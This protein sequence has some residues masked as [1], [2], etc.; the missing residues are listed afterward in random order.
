MLFIKGEDGKDGESG[1]KGQKGEPGNDVSYEE[2]HIC[3]C[4][5]FASYHHC[6]FFVF[7]LWLGRERSTRSQWREWYTWSKRSTWI[8]RS[9]RNEGN[10]K[11]VLSHLL[12]LLYTS[13]HSTIIGDVAVIYWVAIAC[14]VFFL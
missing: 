1:M 12:Q 7:F 14:G 8:A 11:T 10:S 9:P 3:G 6:F 5:Y 2:R 4:G 13:L